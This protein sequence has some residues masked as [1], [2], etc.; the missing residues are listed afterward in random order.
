MNKKIIA[1]GLFCLGFA[2]T[3]TACGDDDSSSTGGSTEMV[4]CYGLTIF[5]ND[6][7]ESEWN[8]NCMQAE[9]GTKMA[10][11]LK[12]GCQVMKEFIDESKGE[13]V[14]IGKGCPSDKKA[15]YSCDANYKGEDYTSYYYKIDSEDTEDMVVEGDAK[16]TC[17]NLTKD[18]QDG[19]AMFEE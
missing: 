10:T 5:E 11:L 4:S 6:G 17:E 3:F 15:L 2:A 1:M 13:K 8:E 14:E 16:K 9:A 12:T 19:F 7:D 18:E